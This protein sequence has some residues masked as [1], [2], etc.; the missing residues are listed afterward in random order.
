[1]TESPSPAKPVSVLRVVLKGSLW[2]VVLNL[3]FALLNPM[4]Q[5]NSLTIYNW[6]VPGRARLPF[7]EDASA[8]NLSLNSLEAMFAS[9]QVTQPKAPNEF[10]VLVIG[11]SSVWGIL[12]R[13]E[14]TLTSQIN[15]AQIVLEDGRTLRAYNLGHPVLSLAK[16][17]L[18]LNHALR[19][20][21][22]MIVWLTTLH[23]F[24]RDQQLSAPLVQN[25]AHRVRQLFQNS[26]MDYDL[27][28][29]L[30]TQPGLLDRTIVGQ[31]R[32]LADWLRLQLYGIMWATT[33]IDQRYPEEFDLRTSDFEEDVTWDEVDSPRPLSH[34]DLAFDMIEAGHQI[35]GAVPILMVN[36]SIFISSGQNSDIRYNLWYPRWAYD[37]YRQLY[38]EKAT[39]GNWHYLDLW[40]AIDPDEFTDSPVHLTPAGTQ[41][42]AQ[43]LQPAMM[44]IANERNH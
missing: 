22:D 21:P 10:R 29:T 37:S 12:L 17:L 30:P 11:D 7:G 15:D 19:Y 16:D 28:N 26:A 43:R 5:V 20:E 27:E 18:I 36:E 4:P 6:L 34:N 38:Q 31:R 39:T 44:N 2:F 25:N 23:S 32:P 33:G 42:L 40:D 3:A 1:M 14:E 13:P 41:Q 35:A 24:P 8:Y 9:H